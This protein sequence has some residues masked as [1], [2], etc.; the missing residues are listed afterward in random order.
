MWQEVFGD[1]VSATITPIEQG[2]YI[3]LA[4][5]GNFQAQGWRQHGSADPDSERLWWT[6]GNA[7]P[8]GGLS[9]N[10]GR[11]QDDVIDENLEIIKTNPDEDGPPG[12][13]RGDQPALRR[14]GVLPLARRGRCG[15]SRQSPSVNGVETNTLVDSGEQG[16]GL[17]FA[18]RHQVNQ[19]WCDDGACE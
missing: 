4:L 14:A 1:T 16:L 18:G 15:A 5:T 8:I 3:G 17:A 19:I 10:F 11:L 9:L 2:A 13:R 7:G 12:G 6:S